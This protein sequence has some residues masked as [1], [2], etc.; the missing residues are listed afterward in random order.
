MKRRLLSMFCVLALCLTL[1][2]TVAFAAEGSKTIMLGASALQENVNTETAATVYFGLNQD[3]NPAAWR[4]IGYDGTGAGGQSGAVTLLAASTMGT[5]RF[6][7]DGTSNV[8][9]DSDLKKAIDALA[10]KLTTVENAAAT[11]QTL[12]SGN[13]NG[14]DTDC[15]AG[16]QVDNAV[17]W[18]LATAEANRVDSSIRGLSTKNWLMYH[19]WLRS[20]GTDSRNTA[21]VNGYGT[22]YSDGQC[23]T[24]TSYGVRPAFYFNLNSVLFASAAVGGKSASGM[25]S[26]LT[27]VGDYG[28]NEWKLTLLD[29][30]RNFSISD[31]KTEESKVEFFYSGAQI[32]TNEYIS[33]VMESNGTITHYGRILQLDG[34]T[35]GENGTASLT[36]PE[37]VTFGDTTK[38][39]IFNEQYNG[40]E[41]DNTKLTDYASK[42][43]EVNTTALTLTAGSADRTSETAA[44]VKFTSDEVGEYYYAVVE[45]S[46][47]EP[48]IDTT[49]TGT[50]CDATEQTISLTNLPGTGAMDIYIVVK[51]AVGNVSNTLK[52]GIPEYSAPSYGI[53]VFPETLD[54]DSKTAGYT[55]APAAQT[56]TIVNTGNQ[57]V[58]V[59]LPISTNYTITPGECFANDTAT[60]ALNGTATF[61]A[62]PNTGL[63]VSSYLETLA[64]SGSNNISA[65]VGLSFEVLATYTLT[66]NFEPERYTVTLSDAGADAAGGG[67]YETGQ[68]ITVT[69]RTRTGYTFKNWTAEGVTLSSPT[70]ATVTFPMP[71]NDVILTASWTANQPTNPGGGSSSSSD[72][73]DDDYT[74]PSSTEHNPDSSTT[75]TTTRNDGAKVETTKWPDGSKEVVET[76]PLTAL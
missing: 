46:K 70:S 57:P 51:D 24:V 66:A 33:V 18:P 16:T 72:D 67:I 71:E 17:F 64:V 54:F 1:L 4:V 49:E 38:L 20:P 43:I 10:E 56:V 9:A 15:V 26:G 22:V 13:Y 40:G 27:A 31:A 14:A 8:Y 50:S 41:N 5:T 2:P 12:T 53:S 68:T 69:A 61:T 7:T 65:S 30:S 19:W 58:T 45:S 63:A 74:P 25:G 60:L 42:M 3:S 29:S 47:T 21:Y 44:T 35:N 73:D 23:V 75:T 28:G 36:L 6:D 48:T 11:G 76:K 55:E 52:I 37:G 59:T 62:Q 34:T 32:E 39:Y